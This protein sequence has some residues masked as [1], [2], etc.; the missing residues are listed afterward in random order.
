MARSS[1]KWVMYFSSE[2]GHGTSSWPGSSGMPTEWR[3]GTKSAL[4]SSILAST[5][6]P[7]RVM[8]FIDNAT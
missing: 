6:A 7:M 2:Q 8:I 1:G 3:H 4:V 5:S